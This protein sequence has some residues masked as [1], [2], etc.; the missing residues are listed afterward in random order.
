MKMEINPERCYCYR[1]THIQNLPHVLE[2]GLVTQTH[3]NA[4]ATYIRIGN[5]EIIDT[6]SN[7]PVKVTGYG[8]IGDY[9]PFYFT[10]RSVMLY[11]IVT[12][13]MAPLVPKRKRDEIVV[14]RCLIK[15]LTTLPNWFFSTGQANDSVSKHFTD[16]SHLDQIDWDSI[17]Q[18][19][20]KKTD[21]DY[22]R[23]RRYQAE[24]LV[25]GKVPLD[26]FESL[27]VCDNSTKEQ[28]ENMLKARNIHNLPVQITPKYFF[29]P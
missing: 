18:S 16:L 7:K 28:L 9:V 20:F 19:N 23:P 6:R 8:N 15:Q 13:Y 12:G 24:F 4:S 22:D 25:R 1:I 2:R 3:T 26:C 14:I 17:Q 10:P 27:H 5:P 21:G 11:N 29:Q